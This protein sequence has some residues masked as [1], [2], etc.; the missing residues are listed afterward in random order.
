MRIWNSGTQE[1]KARAVLE[2]L[3]MVKMSGSSRLN[4]GKTQALP[5]FQI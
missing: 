5:E 3:T 2:M 1:K 4:E